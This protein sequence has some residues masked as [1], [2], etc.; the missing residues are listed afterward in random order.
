MSMSFFMFKVAMYC[1]EAVQHWIIN[2]LYQQN[3]WK[4]PYFGITTTIIITTTTAT[5]IIIATIIYAISELEFFL[6]PF[7][8]DY[9][10]AMTEHVF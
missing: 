2:T 6:M 8:T 10:Q 5:N 9:V 7:Q 3:Y 4:Y 1:F